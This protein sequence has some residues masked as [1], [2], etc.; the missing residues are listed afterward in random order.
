MTNVVRKPSAEEVAAKS[1]FEVDFRVKQNVRKMRTLWVAI[2]EDLFKVW[3][4]E[5]WKDLGFGGFEDWLA[6]P[7]VAISK[8]HSYGLV[9]AW[10]ELVVKR[11]VTPAQLE[12]VGIGGLREVLP[13]IRRGFVDVDEGLTDARELGRADLRHKYGSSSTPTAGPGTPRAHEP[14]DPGLEPEFAIC[15]ACGSRY[16]VKRDLL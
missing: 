16:P 1:A 2:A 6:Q 10:R 8:R 3:E 5:L 9:E 12:G 14:I 4:Q 11:A 7:E 15:P 13:A